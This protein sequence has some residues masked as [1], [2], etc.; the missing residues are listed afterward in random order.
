MDRVYHR[1]AAANGSLAV[2]CIRSLFRSE[3]VAIR[4]KLAGFMVAGYVLLGWHGRLG[5]CRA[6]NP[7]RANRTEAPQGDLYSIS[8]GPVENPDI[9]SSACIPVVDRE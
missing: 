9:V 7:D 6:S 8:A 1:T 3:N 4:P 5:L 2:H